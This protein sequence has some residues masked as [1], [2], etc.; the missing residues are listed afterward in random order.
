MKTCFWL[1]ALAALPLCAAPNPIGVI[2][3]VKGDVKLA[4]K[5]SAAVPATGAALCL[6]GARIETGADGK[7]MLRLLPD[8]AFVD[9][10]P[11]SVFSLKRV[12]TH[13]ASGPKSEGP[14]KD[15][16]VRRLVLEKAEVVVGLKK[17]SDPVQCENAQTLAT[18]AAG[19][20]SCRSDEKG[21][22]SFLVQDG[23]LTIYN[24]PKD[25]TATVRAGQKAVSDLDGIRISDATDADL[26]QIG[27]S[28][29]TLEVDF[30]NPQTED[31]TTLEVE[32][33][34]NF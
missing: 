18:A 33:E 9:V 23:E 34:S 10:R 32:Y 15:Q 27:F 6:Q 28:Q 11:Q 4:S 24:R 22:A 13:V 16:R 7:A 1:L 31:F 12:K 3:S 17:K 29:N 8:N 26:D 5:D 30:V 20:F 25:I 19:R 14:A 21:T 2:K